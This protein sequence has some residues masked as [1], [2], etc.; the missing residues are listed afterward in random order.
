M[1][2]IDAYNSFHS[3]PYFCDVF[4]SLKP[5]RRKS[6]IPAYFIFKAE[7]TNVKS[8]VGSKVSVLIR[9]HPLRAMMHL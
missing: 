5:V 8:F 4:S 3:N 1:S 2:I 9:L 7:P 6:P